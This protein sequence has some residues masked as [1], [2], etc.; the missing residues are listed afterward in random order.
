MIKILILILGFLFVRWCLQSGIENLSVESGLWVLIG[1][2]VG[3]ALAIFGFKWLF[4]LI[5]S[6][7]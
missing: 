5:E 7:R 1:A 6:A 2:A 3:A 4:E